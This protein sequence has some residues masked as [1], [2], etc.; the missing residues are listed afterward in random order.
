[1]AVTA[2]TPQGGTPPWCIEPNQPKDDGQSANDARS[3]KKRKG[4]LGDTC[5]ANNNSKTTTKSRKRS[6]AKGNNDEDKAT[7]TKEAP[8]GHECSTAPNSRK[9]SSTQSAGTKN[10]V[11]G[12]TPSPNGNA[13]HNKQGAEDADP[14]KQGANEKS[15][16]TSRSNERSAYESSLSHDSSM[17]VPVR[18]TTVSKTVFFQFGKTR[19]SNLTIIR[20]PSLS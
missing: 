1:M 17:Q 6:S 4:A 19:K 5:S 8:G 10:N 12:A 14:N 3:Q 7:G 18:N 13:E 2:K 16:E 15:Q 11:D 20:H 9:A